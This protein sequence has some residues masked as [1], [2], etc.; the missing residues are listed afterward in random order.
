MEQQQQQQERQD[1]EEDFLVQDQ[2]QRRQEVQHRALAVADF[3]VVVAVLVV[4][5]LQ[6]FL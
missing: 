2:P 5:L 3:L 6:Y 1:L 4:F